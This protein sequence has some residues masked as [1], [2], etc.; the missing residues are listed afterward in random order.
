VLQRVLDIPSNGIDQPDFLVLTF[1]LGIDPGQ[2]LAG[3]RPRQA[4]ETA[5]GF[6]NGLHDLERV[7]FNQAG[8]AALVDRRE[9]LARGVKDY[10]GTG[11]QEPALEQVARRRVPDQ[12]RTT[13]INGDGRFAVWRKRHRAAGGLMLAL[14]HELAGR[15]IPHSG[16]IDIA[17]ARGGSDPLAIG[18]PGKGRYRT[19]AQALGAKAEQGTWRQGV[20]VTIYEGRRQSFEHIFFILALWIGRDRQGR[21]EKGMGG[22]RH[23]EKDCDQEN[24]GCCHL[25]YLL[26]FRQ[27]SCRDSP[28]MR[29][30]YKHHNDPWSRVVMRQPEFSN[31]LHHLRGLTV[32]EAT[33]KLTDAQLLERFT[34]AQDETAFTV[35]VQRHARLVWAVCR[36]TLQHQQDAEDALQAS[37]LV[38][39]TRARSIKKAASLANWL[40]G[41]AFRT[42][43]L[44]K[45]RAAVQRSHEEKARSTMTQS[46]SESETAW[47]EL[48]GVLDS[49][50]RRLPGKYAAPF[51]LCCLEGRSGPEAARQLG[52]KEGTVTNRLTQARKLLRQRLVRR[53]IDLSLVLG[54]LAVA[55]RAAPAAG[56]IRLAA[57]VLQSAE[58]LQG[59]Q[60]VTGAVS[61]QVV[62]LANGVIKAMLLTK[63]KLSAAIVLTVTMLASGV[64]WGAR[65]MGGAVSADAQLL[66]IE[67][68]QTAKQKQANLAPEEPTPKSFRPDLLPATQAAKGQGG[69]FDLFGDPLPNGVLFRLGTTRL[70]HGAG[71]VAVRFAPGDR[72]IASAGY[73]WRFRLWDPNSAKEV[74]EGSLK[75]GATALAFSSRGTFVATGTRDGDIDVWT[76]PEGRNKF[77]SNKFAYTM[78]KKQIIQLAFAEQSNYLI[79]VTGDGTVTWRDLAKEISV[80]DWRHRAPITKAAFSPDMRTLAVASNDGSIHLLEPKSGKTLATLDDRRQIIADLAFSPDGA[81]LA[82]SAN[83]TIHFWDTAKAREIGMTEEVAAQYF[84]LAF[85]KDGKQIFAGDGLGRLKEFD[86][87]SAKETKQLT[88]YFGTI[89][90]LAVSHDGKRLLAGGMDN[91]VHLWDLAQGEEMHTGQGHEGAVLAMTMASNGK[92]LVTASNDSTVLFWDLT[93]HT[94]N[95][96]I[97]AGGPMYCV[98]ASPKGDV[99]AAGGAEPTIHLWNVAS[100]EE[101]RAL[102]GPESGTNGLAFSPDHKLL[103]GVGVDE[104]RLWEVATGEQLRKVRRPNSGKGQSLALCLAFTPDGKTLAVGGQSELAVSLYDVAQDRETARLR[105]GR[106][107]SSLAFSSTGRTLVT[108]GV[109]SF[110]QIWE[111]ASG[112]LRT[113]LGPLHQLKTAITA[114]AVTPDDRRIVVVPPSRQFRI[115]DMMSAEEI[116]KFSGHKGMV[117]DLAFSPDGKRLYS[118]SADTT[119]CAW[120]FAAQAKRTP[121]GAANFAEADLTQAWSQLADADAAEAYHAMGE[122]CQSPKQAIQLIKANLHPTTDL[123]KQIATWIKELDRA[124]F[125]VRQKAASALEAV[126]HEAEPALLKALAMNSSLEMGLR[127]KK[128]LEKLQPLSP[129]RLRML[130]A[131][132]ILEYLGSEEGRQIVESL[133]RGAPD[134][135]LTRQANVS[136]L[137]WTRASR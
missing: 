114:V 134:S 96:R 135:W 109:D 38:L 57:D 89:L 26:G 43:M 108:A 30:Y 4:D 106:G 115:F 14:A 76:V 5:L 137:H 92:T 127:V 104:L 50:I 17:K 75:T 102:A 80:A 68:V 86:V 116:G 13:L 48:L 24:F 55:Y 131:L 32:P 91:T 79:S 93:T 56:S 18:R 40:H 87:A 28:A 23:S 78:P 126:A 49:E 118:G 82:W 111:V 122:L 99:V 133:S 52:W 21:E 70:R 35:L 39:A 31:I 72:L 36:N 84:A 59:G 63:L 16:G 9:I 100:G 2:H 101:I 33:K 47:R 45:R 132:E 62:A 64:G 15:G 136:L 19:V 37:F 67:E 77:A 112:K 20:A 130:R 34:A 124:E 74:Y 53:G 11:G 123:D 61:S 119:I 25:M 113:S 46:K 60:A 51:V 129:E 94:P 65:Q 103:A 88:H 66:V 41:V 128:V 58:L 12:Q 22:I 10:R 29:N 121:T 83:G 6:A 54:G 71:V 81:T 95:R 85:S 3:F 69:G 1:D 73:E 107:V 7:R 105:T 110:V 8:L 125:A 27:K 98:S 97:K 117:H 44:V 90:S 42:A 120:D